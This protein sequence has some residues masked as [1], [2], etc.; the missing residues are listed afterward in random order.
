MAIH[1]DTASVSVW[2][3]HLKGGPHVVVS[4]QSRE[5][6]NSFAGCRFS[7]I[8]NIVSD[9]CVKLTRRLS[10]RGGLV[11]SE[12]DINIYPPHRETANQLLQKRSTFPDAFIIVFP[13]FIEVN[14]W[15]GTLTPS[16]YG[17]EV[18][19]VFADDPDVNVTFIKQEE[20]G[21]DI[22]FRIPATDLQ[23][24]DELS[25]CV[26]LVRRRLDL[27]E[28][29]T[30][31]HY[32]T[33]SIEKTFSFPEEVGV[34]CEQYLVYFVQ[35]LRDLGVNATSELKHKAGQVLF[36]VTPANEEEA[37]D[38]IRTALDVYLHLPASPV[39]N[40]MSNEIAI[41]RLESQVLRF[42]SDLRLASA[43][44]QAKSATI[45]AQQLTINVQKALL[46][47]EI[48]L[49][50][51]KDV[52]PKKDDDREEFLGGTVALTVFKDKGVEVNYAKMFRKLRDLFFRKVTSDKNP[53]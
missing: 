40:D 10:Y 47:G 44:L 49:D 17:K 26:S 33:N 27:L 31:S 6:L 14:D 50:S 37:L 29:G 5:A 12:E 23:I 4:F 8:P 15:K 41:Q 30:S 35:F 34:A 38:N 24:G 48:L 20:V 2:G 32:T 16:E 45:E 51:M 42:Q 11:L 19:E 39:G 25:R 52:T 22:T 7:E 43:E 36:T 46:N 18:S 21:F 13:F 1:L 9:V 53:R 28:T 3:Q